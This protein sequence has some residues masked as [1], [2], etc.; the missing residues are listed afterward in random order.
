MSLRGRRLACAAGAEEDDEDEDGGC[1][2]AG[3]D[4]EDAFRAYGVPDYCIGNGE[5]EE[6]ALTTGRAPRHASCL[7]A[8][9]WT[10]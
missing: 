9:C 7:S 2:G 5:E 10:R 6:A 3:N 1:D 8:S 4:D